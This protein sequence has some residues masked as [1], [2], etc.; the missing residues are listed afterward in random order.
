MS[1][2]RDLIA[3]VPNRAAL[4]TAFSLGNSIDPDRPLSMLFADLDRFGAV[5]RCHGRAVGDQV[6]AAVGARLS[7]SLSRKDVAFRLSADEFIIATHRDCAEADAL[8]RQLIKAMAEPF[9][10]AGGGRVVI[11]V[12]IGTVHVDRVLSV[13]ALEDLIYTTGTAM[14]AAKEQAPGGLVHRPH[15][16]SVSSSPCNFA[17]SPLPKVWRP[18]PA[19]KLSDPV[20]AGPSNAPWHGSLAAA[21]SAAATDVKPT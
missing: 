21:D 5:N 4:H 9:E 2:K 17:T 18:A 7:C 19:Q 11:S 16:S 15:I 8:A 12:S 6:I 10:P 14:Y 13:S 3:A 20:P 1:H